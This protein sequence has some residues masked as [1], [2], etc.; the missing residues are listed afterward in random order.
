MDKLREVID[1]YEQVLLN[2]EYMYE[3]FGD[4]NFIYSYFIIVIVLRDL[5]N[6]AGETPPERKLKVDDFLP[7]DRLEII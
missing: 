4:I 7:P 6:V 1:R 3:Q 5:Y 2:Y